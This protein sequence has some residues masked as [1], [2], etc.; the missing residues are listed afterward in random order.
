MEAAYFSANNMQIIQHA[1]RYG[2]YEKSNQ[3]IPNQNTDTLGIIMRSVYNMY[4]PNV[5]S[6]GLPAAIYIQ[7]QNKE[8]QLPGEPRV[9]NSDMHITQVNRW[10]DGIV[11]M[12]KR[13]VEFCVPQLVIAAKS[14]E[15]YTKSIDNRINEIPDYY[16]VMS[17]TPDRKKPLML[18]VG[19]GDGSS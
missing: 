14:M 13:V 1:V 12:N 17:S 4:L 18:P 6:D 16:P 11:Q 8:N 2:V 10:K 7:S 9:P 5:Y 3:I 19:L 15:T